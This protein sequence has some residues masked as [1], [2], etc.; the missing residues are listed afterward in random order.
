MPAIK[1]RH[2]NNFGIFS[3]GGTFLSERQDALSLQ[4]NV[5][6]ERRVSRAIPRYVELRTLFLRHP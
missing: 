5:D 6:R 4:N 1:D 3:E 2:G